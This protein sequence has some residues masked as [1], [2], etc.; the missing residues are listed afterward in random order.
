MNN[1]SRPP[2]KS[3]DS[4][5]DQRPALKPDFSFFRIGTLPKVSLPFRFFVVLQWMLSF[6]PCLNSIAF[7]TRSLLSYAFFRLTLIRGILGH[8]QRGPIR[9]GSVNFVI[10]EFSNRHRKNVCSRNIEK[11]CRSFSNHDCSGTQSQ[12]I[13]QGR[14]LAKAAGT[15]SNIIMVKLKF[16]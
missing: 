3:L 14:H 12:P 8:F 6:R 10:D 16:K 7:L 15:I 13:T 2:R 1:Y 5:P 4:D 11:G 9:F